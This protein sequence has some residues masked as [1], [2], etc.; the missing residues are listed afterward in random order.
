MTI[1]P[2]SNGHY[3][4]N[5][6]IKVKLPVAIAAMTS[7]P[8]ARAREPEVSEDRLVRECENQLRS[9]RDLIP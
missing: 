1:G 3:P 8:Q 6:Y 9:W 4:F 5:F 2:A 7:R